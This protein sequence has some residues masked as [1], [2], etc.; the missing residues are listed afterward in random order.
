MSLP[1]RLRQLVGTA[2]FW[3]DYLGDEVFGKPVTGLPDDPYLEFPLT[4]EYCLRV[5]YIWH[6]SHEESFIEATR[7]LLR[8]TVSCQDILLGWR[9][10]DGHVHPHALRWEEAD[11]IGRI[12]ALRNPELPH[13]GIPFLLLLPYIA[14]IEGSDHL[15][16]LRLLNAALRSLGVFNERQIRYRLSTFNKVPP[17]SEWRRVHPHGWVCQFL[18]TYPSEG[19]GRMIHSLRHIPA[20]SPGTS[21]QFP[22]EAWNECMHQA[23]CTLAEVPRGKIKKSKETLPSLSERIELYYQITN[24]EAAYSTI[25][26]LR[27]AL[28]LE[29]LGICDLSGSWNAVEDPENLVAELGHP[30]AGDEYVLVCYGELSVIVQVI[31]RV[32]EEAGRPEV[33]LFQRLPPGSRQFYRRI[34]L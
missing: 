30:N 27:R 6:A 34:A 20:R 32:V 25:P 28:F 33:R 11:L 19:G 2:E 3:S 8:T 29:G 22:F 7:L 24:S 13:P 18:G 16:G 14:S 31:R 23:E 9:Q 21:P 17:G 4:P 12:Q 10:D 15:L 1:G 26:V 5:G